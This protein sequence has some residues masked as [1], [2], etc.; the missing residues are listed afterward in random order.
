MDQSSTSRELY[1]AGGLLLLSFLLGYLL[2]YPYEGVLLFLITFLFIQFYQALRL[3]RWL[4]KGASGDAPVPSGIWGD[5]YY[6]LYRQR[7]QDKKRKK[8]LAGFLNQFKKLTEALPDATVVLTADND[9]EWFN[10][11]AAEVLGLK[12]NDR[13]EHIV[14]FLRHPDFSAYL[15]SQDYLSQISIPSP[16]D[17]ERELGVRIVSYGAGQR[18]LLVQDVSELKQ[19]E[20]MRNDFVANVSHE[21]KTPLTVLRGYVELM[22]FSDL[23]KELDKPIKRMGEQVVRMRSLVDDLLLIARLESE[24]LD[25]GRHEFVNI[26]AL[27]S[28]ICAEA[29]QLD[30]C[31]DLVLELNSEHG[32]YGDSKELESAFS[33]LIMNAVGYTSVEGKITVRWS[34]DEQGGCLA[35]EDSG[36]GI[37]ARHIPFLTKRF[38]RVD[39]GR[40]REQGGT[41]LGL[42]IV[43][44]VLSRHQAELKIES[45]PGKGSCFSCC[46]PQSRVV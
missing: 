39:R 44:Y 40:S 33:N 2:G 19:L 45:T 29:R 13:G 17:G 16:V 41:G 42:S 9:I 8:R 1:R 34:E 38:Y 32:L 26:S 3:E 36:E 14:N 5:I 43:K 23:P 25:E 31:P 46:F 10:K 15:Y 20:K 12:R 6:H 35:V 22:E 30:S 11:A 27:L 28:K 18:L 4:R 37:A 24:K 7:K 21:L